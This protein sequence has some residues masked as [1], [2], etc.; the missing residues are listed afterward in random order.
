MFKVSKR[1]TR[2]RCGICSKLTTKT[3]EWRH[4]RRS[5]VFIINFWTYFKPFSSVSIV[6][7]EQENARWVYTLEEKHDFCGFYRPK[8]KTLMTLASLENDV[9]SRQFRLSR[10]LLLNRAYSRKITWAAVVHFS[11]LNDVVLVLDPW[12]CQ[13]VCLQR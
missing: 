4:S 11:S 10:D 13:S 8:N 9:I 12:I 5:G 3:P 7:F 2:S 1:N 6:N